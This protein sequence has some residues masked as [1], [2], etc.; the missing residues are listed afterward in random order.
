V[1]RQRWTL[2]VAVLVAILVAIV[3]WR[4]SEPTPTRLR[5]AQ[6]ASIATTPAAPREEPS[7]QVSAP[8][9]RGR[10]LDA[11]GKPV[12]GAAVRLLSTAPPYGVVAEASTET[13]GGFAF[14]DPPRSASRVRI[15]ADHDPE[16]V[17]TSAELRPADG[18]TIDVT[19]VLSPA[20]V[21]GTVVDEKDHPVAGVSLSVEGVAWKT[22]GAISDEAGAFRLPVVPYEATTLVAV[23]SG[24]R[25]ARVDLGQRQDRPEVVVQVRLDAGAPVDGRVVDPDGNAARARVVA[26]EG[27]A[28][29]SRTTSGEDG[30]FTLPAS[31]TG[32]EAKAEADDFA[33]S[34]PA[35]VP[36]AGR[37]TLRLRSGGAI[38]GTVVDERGR[39]IQSFSLGIESYSG[40]RSGRGAQKFEDARGAFTLD[41]LPPGSYVLT[42][43]AEGKP[44]TRSD[45]IE[46]RGGTTTTGVRIVLLQGGSVVGRV[47][48]NHRAPL[49]GAELHF[50][51]V[52]A[53]VDDGARATTDAA[54][55]YRL[56][57]APAGP[58]TL[59]I[60]KQGYRTKLVPGLR[61]DSGQTLKQ[62]VT[63]PAVNGGAG[64]E[65]AGIGA[66]LG[67]NADGIFVAQVFGGDPADRAG[68]RSGDHIVSIDG[69][70][71]SSMSV[72]DAVQRLRGPVGTS[73]GISI[74]RGAQ[75]IDAVIERAAIVH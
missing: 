58:F 42:A 40:H 59:R 66:G 61:V 53:I 71:A 19:L 33:P 64:M 18:E 15:V 50:D 39:S 31:T 63:L 2:A 51:L 12:D 38:S 14:A 22:R 6:A 36:T 10:I 4:A 41:R 46:V 28:S 20:V 8:A 74:R 75:T 47:L 11:D 16:G 43:T 1:S 69:D 26:C 3:A 30:S 7:A 56:D 25:T 37:L 55:A 13:S 57:G 5:R 52:S 34:E 68:L 9:I 60:Q 35:V 67:Q 44:P 23:A 27:T 65:L 17:V 32:C 70:D 45:S 62:D 73:V 72:A 24:Y 21:R 54:G 29:E 48:D 49:Q